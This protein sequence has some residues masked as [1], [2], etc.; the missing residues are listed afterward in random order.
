MFALAGIAAINMYSCGVSL[1]MQYAVIFRRGLL[2]FDP[3]GTENARSGF[4]GMMPEW[5]LSGVKAI[6]DLD[7]LTIIEAIEY[8]I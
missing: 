8:V 2:L 3:D 6:T 7:A 1:C 5:W 4:L